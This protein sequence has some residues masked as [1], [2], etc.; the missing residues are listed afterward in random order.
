MRPTRK[1]LEAIWKPEMENAGWWFKRIGIGLAILLLAWIPLR[2]IHTWS[3]ASSPAANNILPPHYV[4][5]V[6]QAV[7]PVYPGCNSI[8]TIE[9]DNDPAGKPI[10]K[11]ARC[12]SRLKLANQTGC[13]QVKVWGESSWRPE[14][15]CKGSSN[16]PIPDDVEYIRSARPEVL[17]V[18]VTLLGPII[19]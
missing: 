12:S 15:F 4:A 14:T 5:P 8:D 6:G 13:I 11:G 7:A 16:V 10:N 9:V 18:K 2:H 17:T 1:Q 3:T 19:K